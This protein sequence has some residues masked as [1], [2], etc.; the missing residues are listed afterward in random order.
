MRDCAPGTRYSVYTG[1]FIYSDAVYF[2]V[3]KCTVSG[4]PPSACFLYFSLLGPGLGGARREALSVVGFAARDDPWRTKTGPLPRQCAA[5]LWD[6]WSSRALVQRLCDEWRGAPFTSAAGCFLSSSQGSNGWS[7][8]LPLASQGEPGY[9]FTATMVAEWPQGG[10][11][12][13]RWC[14]G[15]RSFP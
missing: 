3:R 15:R 9:C 6:G 14:S 11:Q 10:S 5:R 13:E 1:I 2:L 12:D 7:E 4:D 8:S